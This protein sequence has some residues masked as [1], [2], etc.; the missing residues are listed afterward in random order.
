MDL[1][2]LLDEDYSAQRSLRL[3]VQR[4]WNTRRI[5]QVCFFMLTT[6]ETVRK[7]A[8]GKGKK[9]SGGKA[10]DHETPDYEP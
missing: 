5:W 2:G 7:N 1:K 9:T 6:H 8:Q 10:P 4:S 3:L